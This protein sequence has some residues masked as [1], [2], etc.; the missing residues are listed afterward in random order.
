[1]TENLAKTGSRFARLDQLY[2]TIGLVFGLAFLVVTPPFQ[3]PDEPNH[4][5]RC[6]QISE[7]HLRPEIGEGLPGGEIPQGVIATV[8]EVGGE[9]A[10]LS[11]KQVT[12]SLILEYLN[13]YPAK[14]FRRHFVSFPNT[15]LYSPVPYVPALTGILIGKLFGLSPLW[16]LYLGRLTSLLST[17]LLCFTAIRIAPIFAQGFLLIAATPIFLTLAASVSAD[18]LTNGLT[19]LLTALILRS[20]F[21]ESR[22]STRDLLIIAIVSVALALCKNLYFI[23]APLYFV[24]PRSQIGS[25]KKYIM[26]GLLIVALSFSASLIWFSSVSDMFVA[27]IPGG[28]TNLHEPRQFILG[29]PFLFTKMVAVNLAKYSFFYVRSGVGYLGWLNVSLPGPMIA[30]Y[31]M[32]TVAVALVTVPSPR[33]S[34]IQKSILAIVGIAGVAL[35]IVGEFVVWTEAGSTEIR[36]AQGRHFIPFAALFFLLLQNS[37]IGGRID[38]LSLNRAVV[39]FVGAFLL[40]S[41]WIAARKFY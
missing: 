28:F 4:F 11:D 21:S 33:L 6:F 41:L 20:A 1:M 38:K 24:I 12:L 22:V 29:H 37:R 14:G 10:Y 3:V 2:L 18:A 36:E 26:T 40:V 5:F 30:L 15:A 35:V 31:V 16:L 17:L 8:R 39:V 19:I 34:N 32:S 23:L 9:Y 25:N 7:G 13:Y 27:Y